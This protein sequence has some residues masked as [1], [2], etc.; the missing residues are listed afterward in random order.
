M[1]AEKVC[2]QH[3]VSASSP[4][5]AAGHGFYSCQSLVWSSSVDAH[6]ASV[7]VKSVQAATKEYVK[8]TVVQRF[9]NK[10]YK[11]EACEE[12]KTEEWK[13]KCNSPN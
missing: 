10:E 13:W 3:I 2:V 12:K 5:C 7:Q 4:S 6:V 8:S 9:E 1:A 11:T